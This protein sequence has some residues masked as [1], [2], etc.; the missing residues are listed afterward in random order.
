LSKPDYDVFHFVAMR[1]K[2]AREWVDEFTLRV[3]REISTRALRSFQTARFEA[4]LRDLRSYRTAVCCGNRG[5]S[6]E[7]LGL[8]W[9]HSVL[10]YYFYCRGQFLRASAEMDRAEDTVKKAVA[11]SDFLL[12][13]LSICEE[14]L[15]QKARIDRQ[16]NQWDSMKHH[17]EKAER[18]SR[19]QMPLCYIHE[20]PVMEADITEYFL[21]LE[22]LNEQERDCSYIR[23]AVDPVYRRQLSS[24]V[25]ASIYL[26]PG[27]VIPYGL[28]H[29]A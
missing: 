14:S 15:I 29:A 1:S 20:R 28:T 6:V 22:S 13:M 19:N 23:S 4:G 25:L 27:F 21:Q 8:R 3:P 18:M 16:Q 7:F 26:V 2:E 11:Q 17:L 9:Y 10:A 24:T 5:D 12:P